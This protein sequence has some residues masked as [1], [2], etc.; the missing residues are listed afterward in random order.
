[1]CGRV[2]FAWI[3]CIFWRFRGENRPRMPKV[4]RGR[5]KYPEGWDQVEPT[6]KEFEKKFRDGMRAPHH[7]A[8]P[9][10]GEEE[11]GKGREQRSET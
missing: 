3:R 4:A 2:G 5:I 1:M 8:P 10:A 9:C 6:L 7:L 11:E